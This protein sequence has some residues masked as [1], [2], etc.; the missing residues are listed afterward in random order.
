MW[1]VEGVQSATIT[2]LE[3]SINKI[4]I[5]LRLLEG[6]LSYRAVIKEWHKSIENPKKDKYNISMLDKN[7]KPLVPNSYNEVLY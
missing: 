5:E 2:E 6:E 1:T 4:L 7:N 3:Q